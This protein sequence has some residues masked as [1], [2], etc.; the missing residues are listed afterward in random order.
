MSIDPLVDIPLIDFA[1]FLTDGPEGQRRVAKEIFRACHQVGFLYLRNHR[2]PQAAI[3]HALEQSRAFFAL[4]LAEK[5]QLAW[6]SEFS[7]RGYVGMERERLDESQPGD[8][9]E[10]FNVGKE[11]SPTAVATGDTTLVVNR[12]PDGCETFRQTIT[13][14]FQ[15]CTMEME[16]LFRAF[17]IAL[18]MP[19]DYLAERHQTCDYT[20]RLLHYPPLTRA[21]KPGQIRAGAH[22]DY[23]SLTLLFQDQ[24]GDWKC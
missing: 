1:P 21:P 14:F 13:A 24:G 4:P 9:K 22:S 10:A 2:V 8:L 5:Q 7:N 23:G 15:L 18:S 16:P 20:L 6:F 19:I 11:V 3:E 17:A 12:W